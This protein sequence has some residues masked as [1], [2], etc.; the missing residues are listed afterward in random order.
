[1][2]G[3]CIP[4]VFMYP[5]ISHRLEKLAMAST[6]DGYSIDIK[7]FLPY[8]TLISNAI[9]LSLLEWCSEDMFSPSNVVS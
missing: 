7:G 9:S 2:V 6:V 4:L 1:M 8:A 3:D 5:K